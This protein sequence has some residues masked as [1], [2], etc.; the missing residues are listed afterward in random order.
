M[1]EAPS[2]KLSQWPPRQNQN[3]L[4]HRHLK[5]AAIQM[6]K[7]MT[8]SATMAPSALHHAREYGYGYQENP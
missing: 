5:Q 6:M 7:M 8:M 1:I 2:Q 4:R 3:Q